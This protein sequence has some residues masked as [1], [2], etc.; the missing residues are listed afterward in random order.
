[1]AAC[2]VMQFAAL[3]F[4]P[5]AHSVIEGLTS[6]AIQSLTGATLATDPKKTN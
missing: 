6:E 3:S 4:A 2:A 1:V 5:A